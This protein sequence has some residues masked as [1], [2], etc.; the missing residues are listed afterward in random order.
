MTVLRSK[1]REVL[2]WC[3]TQPGWFLVCD[4]SL[5]LGRSQDSVHK[6]FRHMEALNLL[7]RQSEAGRRLMWRVV[8]FDHAQAVANEQPKPHNNGYQKKVRPKVAKPLVN[9]VWSLA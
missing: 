6:Q 3:L 7:E 5:D 4:C 8:D 9:S 1:A 2:R